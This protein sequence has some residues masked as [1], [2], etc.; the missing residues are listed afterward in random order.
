MRA[1][2]RQLGLR[3]LMAPGIKRGAAAYWPE[4]DL[5]ARPAQDIVVRRV[6]EMYNTYLT[7][8]QLTQLTAPVQQPPPAPAGVRFAS[9]PGPSA[10]NTARG[11]GSNPV[12]LRYLTFALIPCTR[13]A[14][15]HEHCYDVAFM[16]QM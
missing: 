5:V 15:T 9:E 12:L 11:L 14:C 7:P 3:P 1:R 8:V 16:V 6:F 2:V 13:S 10:R 4:P